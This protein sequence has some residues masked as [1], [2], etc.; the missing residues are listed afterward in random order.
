M[1]DTN[2][3]NK[4]TSQSPW[5]YPRDHKDTIQTGG[6]EDTNTVSQQMAA[7][8]TAADPIA[9]QPQPVAPEIH[10]IAQQRMVPDEPKNRKSMMIGLIV[11]AVL[12]VIALFGAGYY[13][14]V[15]RVQNGDYKNTTSAIDTMISDVAKITDTTKDWQL[16]HPTGSFSVTANATNDLSQSS[17]I[18]DK[19]KENMNDAK[20]HIDEYAQLLKQLQSSPAITKDL[21]TQKA[22]TD[23]SKAIEGY[24]SFGILSRPN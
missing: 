8:N 2:E 24:K 16:I 15:V 22:Y 6:D 19:A 18:T 23:G 12:L 10:T 11:G 1:Q 21:V 14:M 7:L 17:S 13:F 9:I 4:D 3:P 20:K 5:R